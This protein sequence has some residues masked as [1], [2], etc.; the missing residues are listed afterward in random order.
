MVV[1]LNFTFDPTSNTATAF[2][3]TVSKALVYNIYPIVA[4]GLN[5][6]GTVLYPVEHRVWAMKKGKK[7]QTIDVKACAVRDQQDLFVKV[8]P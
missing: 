4:L 1:A 2:E 8:I 7:W 6:H 5:H 3:V